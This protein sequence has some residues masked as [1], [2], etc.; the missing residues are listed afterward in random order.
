MGL[1]SRD[2][3]ICSVTHL[4]LYKMEIVRIDRPR[5][6]DHL[7]ESSSSDEE[8]L[9]EDFALDFIVFDESSDEEEVQ[10]RFGGYEYEFVDNVA[11]NQKC[12]VCLL[13]MRDA[14]QTSECGHRFCE[15]CLH[16]ILR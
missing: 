16:G 13:P 7:S 6:L 14:V 15:D 3:N 8:E 12:P 4:D 1:T 2:D 5:D 10:P 11:D 9:E